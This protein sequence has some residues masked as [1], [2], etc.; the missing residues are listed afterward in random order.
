MESGDTSS[1][2]SGEKQTL[3]VAVV[4]LVFLVG[5]LGGFLV[6]RE[7]RPATAL[8]R[9]GNAGAGLSLPPDLIRLAAGWTARCGNGRGP[10]LEC[11]CTG[12]GGGLEIKRFMLD[13]YGK[14]TPL[15]T[16]RQSVAERFGAIVTDEATRR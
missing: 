14:G 12:P 6:G 9:S 13:L 4:V 2:G 8:Q 16:I 10:L 11:V 1:R 7:L 15:D 3:L 5:L